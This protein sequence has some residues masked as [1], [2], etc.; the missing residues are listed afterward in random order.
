M[1]R[2][3]NA[4]SVPWKLLAVL[5]APPLM[6]IAALA[7]I[8]P[9]NL[10]AQSPAPAPTFALPSS[11][12]D[13]SSVKVDGSSSMTVI[14]E[15]LKQRFQEKY[16]GTTVNLAANGTDEALQALAK[17]EVD[18]VA[19]G[20]PL[21]AAE[22]A[23]GLKQTPISREKIAI[24]VGADNPY[25]GSLTFDQFA[26]MFRGEIT[27]WS[28]VGGTPGPIRLI[29]HPDSSD[30]RQALSS[31]PVFRQAPFKTGANATQ[32]AQ[33]DTAAIVS[34][35][36]K[37]G[38]SYAIASQVLNQPNLRA[39]ELHNTPPSDPRYPYSQPRGYAYRATNP[40]VL[41][42][43][44]FATSAPGQEA[45]AQAR[46]QESVATSQ[47]AVPAASPSVAP[48]TASPDAM[49][50]PSP[51]ATTAAT[52]TPAKP[53]DLTFLWWL[54]LPLL[55]LPLLLWWMKGRGT[56][57]PV[58]AVPPVAPPRTGRM[59]LTPR[60][61]R[62]AYAYWEVPDA[63]L[64]A[65][66]QAG[67]RDLKVRLYDVTDI[68]NMDQQAPHS[69]KE[70]DCQDDAQD[71]PIPIAVDDRD[72]IAELGYT[73]R[74]NQWVKLARSEPVRVPA[75]PPVANG[76]LKTAAAVAGGTALAAT[77]AA[78]VAH[79]VKPGAAT[80][81][82]PRVI[83]VPRNSE[84]AYVY[85]EASAAQKAELKQQGGQELALRVH[86]A[87]DLDLERQN[88]PSFRQYVVNEPDQD[89]HVSIPQ[90]DRDYVAELGYTTQDYRWLNLARSAAVR[91]P[92]AATVAATASA[93]NTSAANVSAANVSATKLTSNPVDVAAS[94]AAAT[95]A[96]NTDLTPTSSESLTSRL[97][98]AAGTITDRFGDATKAVGAAIAGGAATVAAAPAVKSL[99][100]RDSVD[101]EPEQTQDC[102]IILVPRNSKDAYA[103][104]EV[105]ASDKRKLREQGGRRMM[106]RVHD[107]TNLDL[108]RE[109][110]HN[111]QTYVISEADRDRHVAIPASDRDYLAEVGYF[112]DDNQW[113]RLIRSFHIRVPANA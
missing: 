93:A 36:G 4:A 58:A 88:S 35:L 43:L 37:D 41:A 59:I 23:Q 33:D 98:D 30:T 1:S 71:L 101:T 85:W 46:Q 92:A 18:L 16:P 111:T 70:F 21:T 61:C 13:G 65:A 62:D 29:D 26:K 89:Q 81:T 84:N 60:N 105:S 28:Q 68:P 94:T 107:V 100:E 7:A 24:V 49:L 42:F 34:N 109:P 6:A 2:N 3:K 9:E 50:S 53:T 95:L 86:D 72:Y 48:G 56:A 14:N 76:G 25:K 11:L 73:T 44:G 90:A 10:F 108:D 91:V 112:T 52:P 31:Y 20:R 64:Q 47:G 66:R 15:A 69:M 97:S 40:G 78:A 38:I 113:L 83:M 54:L 110:P 87:T 8:D 82:E 5:T 45:I 63:E 12:P 80:P 67:G 32:I 51:D 19:I 55:G 104:W 17:G 22:S 39:L 57:A 99:L 102:R 75:C 79:S 96:R 27:D 103:Y 74:N 106:L 77:G